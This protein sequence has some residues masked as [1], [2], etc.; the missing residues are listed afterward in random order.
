M[1]H[2]QIIQQRITKANKSLGFKLQRHSVQ[3]VLTAIDHFDSLLDDDGELDKSQ[4][5]KGLTDEEKQWV[6]NERKLVQC[7]F[8]YCASRYFKIIDE[9]KSPVLFN[10]RIPQ[11][12]NL[13][14]WAEHEL[15]GWPIE[16]IQLKARQLGMSLLTEL[17]IAHRIFFWPYTYAIIASS[18]PGKSF[19]MSQMVEFAYDNLPWWLA[20]ERTKFQSGSLMEFKGINTSLSIQH[21]SK[22]SGIG[23]GSTPNCA[24]M[25]ELPDFENAEELI[26]ASLMN[27]IHPNRMTFVVLESTAK[28]FGNWWYDSWRHSR[29]NWPKRR[30]RLRP[31]FLPWYT[32]TD[33]KPTPT[34]LEQHQD[35]LQ[36]WTPSLASLKHKDRAERY[37]REESPLLQQLLG[38]DWTL[39]AHQLLW[40][41]I[42]REEHVE[43][44]IL[45][46]FLEE[47]PADELEAFQSPN[48]SVFTVEEMES[49]VSRIHEPKTVYAIVGTGIPSKFHPDPRELRRDRQRFT[50]R[51]A[52]NPLH[53]G[54]FEFIPCKWTN[55]EDEGES[56][57]GKFLIWEFPQQ[58]EEYVVGCDTSYGMGQDRSVIQVIRKGS[59][60]RYDEQVAE[61]ATPYISAEELWPFCMAIGT[62][63]SQSS[64]RS[65]YPT[66][67]R[68][69][70]EVNAIGRITQLELKKRGWHNFHPWVHID[71]KKL[72]VKHATVEGWYTNQKSRH[73]MMVKSIRAAKN[74]SLLINSRYLVEEMRHLQKEEEDAYISSTYGQHDDRWMAIG[75]AYYSTHFMEVEEDM[76]RQMPSAQDYYDNLPTYNSQPKSLR[77]LPKLSYPTYR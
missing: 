2:P 6:A 8:L 62:W 15:N 59:V 57:Q 58:G 47:N 16:I 51:Y 65:R 33:I 44:R 12:M 49:F 40:W 22:L 73:E 31:I 63:Y 18:D 74:G 17:A 37:V 66:Q 50:V 19:M 38:K 68:Q 29:K 32:G 24:H 28:G 42:T 48:S 45:H 34:W 26:D 64:S 41:E 39:P 77:Q 23:R 76:K 35:Q 53:P 71:R 1:Y 70:I 27:A 52:W 3:D 60:Y 61:F 13:S 25:S 36:D 7:D 11:K 69:V 55:Y 43:K 14:V 20:P 9:S 30:C 10:P 21:G 5:P 54:A 67:C 75:F 72:N 56:W 46:K 4:R